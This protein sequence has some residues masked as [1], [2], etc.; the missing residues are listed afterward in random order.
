VWRDLAEG[1]KYIRKNDAVLALI[2]FAFLIN[3]VALPLTHG[4]MPLFSRDV[5][6]RGP[7]GLAALTSAVAVGAFVGSFA[8][9]ART[10]IARP[11]IFGFLAVLAWFAA[12]TLFS[13][14]SWL[15]V[16]MA[17]L[18]VAGVSQSLSLVTIDTS[19][20]RSTP[21]ELR[22]R[23]MGV[24]AMAVYGL[25]M[26][27]LLVGALADTLGVPT[28]LTAIAVGGAVMAA[29]ITFWLRGMWALS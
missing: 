20:L 5:L 27:L 9:A 18:L 19:L 17:I 23:I 1:G 6:H 13:Q 3:I 16:S 22:G 14:S 10:R 15:F 8:M 28:A 25:P 12:L 2:L 11:G 29:L 7:L 21:A 4:L 26:G 24:R